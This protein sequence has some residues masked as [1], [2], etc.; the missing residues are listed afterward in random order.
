MVIENKI[1]DKIECLTDLVM[2][3][4]NMFHD[5]L[6]SDVALSIILC[7][8]ILVGV[9]NNKQIYQAFISRL[10]FE[11]WSKLNVQEHLSNLCKGTL[12][13]VLNVITNNQYQF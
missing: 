11:Q 7:A 9:L 5:D 3:R 6:P 4:Y 10:G 1:K 8:R 2:K 12:K 13:K